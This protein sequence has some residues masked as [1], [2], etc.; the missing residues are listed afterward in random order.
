MV[1]ITCSRS[2][3]EKQKQ[4]QTKVTVG[5]G[6][7]QSKWVLWMYP[8][9]LTAF[10]QF[11]SAGVKFS[12]RLLIELAMS[13]LLDHAL[14]YTVQFRDPKDSVLFTSKLTPSWIQQF[15][16]L[17]SIVLLSQRGRLSCSLEKELQIKRATTYHLGVLLRGLESEVF[18]DKLMENVNKTHFIVNLDNGCTL[19]FRGDTTV[20]YAKVVSGGDSMTMVIRISRGR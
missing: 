20:K 19:E 10:E 6:P 8:R 15:M 17:Y 2:R 16:H 1:L 11:K 7:K 14:L 13:I 12:F 4:L 18:D 3:L 5:C 9:L